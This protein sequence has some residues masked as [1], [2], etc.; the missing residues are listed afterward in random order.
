MWSVLNVTIRLNL[1]IIEL[2]TKI[3]KYAFEFL[4]EQRISDEKFAELRIK[5]D[6]YSEMFDAESMSSKLPPIA[7]ND[8]LEKEVKI[9]NLLCVENNHT[10]EILFLSVNVLLL[11]ECRG[12]KFANILLFDIE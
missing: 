3:T 8:K 2:W 12:R 5:I 6:E 10:F 7:E 11:R 9:S 4:Q 1:T